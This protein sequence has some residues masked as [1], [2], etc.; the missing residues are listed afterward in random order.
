MTDQLKRARDWIMANKLPERTM[1]DVWINRGM[2]RAARFIDRIAAEPVSAPAAEAV[3]IADALE[4]CDWSGCSIGNKMLLRAAV[5]C[6]R[7]SSPPTDTA[8]VSD[9]MIERACRVHNV[10]WSKWHEPQKKTAREVM[11]SALVA[12][13]ASRP[14]TP[15]EGDVGAA[16][17]VTG[18]EV[19]DRILERSRRIYLSQPE[20]TRRSIDAFLK[21]DIPDNCPQPRDGGDA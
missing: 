18:N 14:A 11:K 1:E 8:L 17:V 12:A 5:Q 6:L 19:M 2:E 13:L 15:A 9:D 10:G 7:A 4:A 20:H 21:S 16:P 3:R